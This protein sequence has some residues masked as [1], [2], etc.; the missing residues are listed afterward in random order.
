MT[1]RTERT[2]RNA[3]LEDHDALVQL[4]LQY[5]EHTHSPST[6]SRLHC[7]WNWLQGSGRAGPKSWIGSHRAPSL[8][9]ETASA[10]SPTNRRLESARDMRQHPSFRAAARTELARI[11]EVGRS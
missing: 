7:V 4:H 11:G 2:K 6:A 5:L 9:D 1:A 3:C 8:A 10:S